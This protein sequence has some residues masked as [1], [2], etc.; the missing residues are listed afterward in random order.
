MPDGEQAAAGADE[1][2]H[3]SD[4]AAPDEARSD[5]VRLQKVLARCGFGSRRT[6]DDLIAAGRVR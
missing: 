5:G 4:A 2:E 6:S 3:M 1:V